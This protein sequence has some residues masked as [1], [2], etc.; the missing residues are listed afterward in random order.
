MGT[1]LSSELGKVQAVREKE[2]VPHL[3]YTVGSLAAYS[4]SSPHSQYGVWEQ[5]LP[6]YPGIA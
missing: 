6:K 4:L 1:W 2:V 3:G 5:P